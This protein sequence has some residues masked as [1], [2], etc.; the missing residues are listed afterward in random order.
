MGETRALNSYFGVEDLDKLEAKAQAEFTNKATSCEMKK[1]TDKWRDKRD[2][3]VD[4]KCV[5]PV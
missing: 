5:T 1:I 3:K 4:L 2:L